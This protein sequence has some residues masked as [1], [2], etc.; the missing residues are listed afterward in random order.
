M[1]YQRWYKQGDP[2]IEFTYQ[3]TEHRYAKDGYIRVRVPP[4]H[5]EAGKNGL[6]YEHRVVW[7][8]ANGPIPPGHDVHH[9]NEDRADNRL[10]NLVLLTKAEHTRLHNPQRPPEPAPPAENRQK[11]VMPRKH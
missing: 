8:D 11:E 4:D 10:E 7:H 2:L 5:P 3:Y 1:H 6:A 9:D